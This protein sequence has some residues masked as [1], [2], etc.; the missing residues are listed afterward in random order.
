[1]TR[2]M[3]RRAA[4]G[5][6][7]IELLVVIAIIAILVGLMMP[8]VQQ[9]REAANRISCTN[10]L[11]QIALASHLYHD[12]RKRLPPT[13]VPGEGPT[14][15]WLILPNLEQQNL[16]SQW[17]PG[18]PFAMAAQ[19]AQQSP[20]P[21]YFCPSRRDAA[22]AG[23]ALPFK[24]RAGCLQI[25]GVRGA[26]GDYAAS[27]GTTG[28]DYPVTITNGPT[29]L[30]NGAMQFA[31]G[32][33]LSGDFPDGTSNT[34]LLGEKHVPRGSYG[35]YP[36]DC[37]IYDGHNPTC[38]ARAGGL[39]FPLA[40]VPTDPGWKFGSNHPGICQFAFCDG[41]VQQVVTT[42]NPLVLGLL[43]QRNDGM[44]IPAG[45]Y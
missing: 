18:I 45:D 29:I 27:I 37:S 19:A 38:N 24:Q 30:P 42:I 2:A 36:W 22:S 35:A 1:M 17:G 33:R 43:T 9:A 10:N 12:Q 44:P 21:L 40:M 25:A 23:D 32:L 34:I 15:A 7:L 6:T 31:T 41:S 39:D 28:A 13:R 11:K 4:A 8:A 14:W 5:F 26:L 16:Y 20:V 3:S